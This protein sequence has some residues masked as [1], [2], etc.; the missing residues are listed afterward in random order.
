MR[1]VNLTVFAFDYDLTWAAFFLNADEH[2]YGRYGGR[3]AGDPEKYLTLAGLKYA[4]R[5]ALAAHRH[6]QR[7]RPPAAA[8]PVRTVEQYAA[9]KRLTPNA[10]IHCHQVYDFRR[11]ELQAAGRWTK[12]E[13]WVYPLPENVGLTLDVT[14]GNRIAAVR[15]D[16][17]AGRAGLRAGD[18]LR[19]LNRQPVASF[20]D[21]QH[22]LHLAPAAGAVPIT[23]QRGA[24][25][26]TGTLQLEPGWRKTDISWRGSMWGLDPTPCVYGPDLTPAEKRQLG[27][28]PKRLAFRQG[29]FIPPPAR[30]AGVRPGD[31]I[32]GIDGKELEMTMLQFNAYVRLSYEV[33]DP[34]T[35]NIIRDGKRLDIPMKLPARAF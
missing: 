30:L 33:G 18:V 16:S 13:V 34:I 9:A 27:L 31:I 2:V 10:C 15:A 14:Q 21:A 1:G 3:D 25:R 26:L 28:G 17:P 4:M 29:N 35:L 5:Q 11:E 20:A 6:A 23:W 22:A 8:Q 24:A 19:D 32:L 7:E 12:D